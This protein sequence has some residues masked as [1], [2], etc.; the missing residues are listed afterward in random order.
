MAIGVVTGMVS[1][2]RLLAGPG[3][4]VVAA[5]GH[6]AA[7]RAK[8]ESLIR[9]GVTG[10][11]SF[12][13][14]GAL[15]PNLR[16]G[17]LV[18]ADAVILPDGSRVDCDA[19]WQRKVLEKVPG[20]S[21]RSVSNIASIACVYDVWLLTRKELSIRMLFK[22]RASRA[23]RSHCCL[24]LL[25]IYASRLKFFLAKHYENLSN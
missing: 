1:E 25:P 16:S 3:Y 20:A 13:I 21:P 5:G 19:A 2:A 4:T 6:A 17:D 23:R 8:T 7:T 14:A 12:G 18:V 9:D 22:S 10:L 24:C 15:D 11:I